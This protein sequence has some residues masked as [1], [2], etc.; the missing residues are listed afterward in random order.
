VC[1]QIELDRHLAVKYYKSGKTTPSS[2]TNAEAPVKG[3][4]APLG[5][6]DR[7]VGTGGMERCDLGVG[8]PYRASVELGGGRDVNPIPEAS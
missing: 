7:Q 3:T 4:G 6:S 8:A 2:G 5:A 1:Q